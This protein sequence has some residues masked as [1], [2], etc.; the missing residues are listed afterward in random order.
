MIGDGAVVAAGSVI[1]R[2]VAA[3]AIAVARG[4]QS[5]YAGAAAKRRDRKESGRKK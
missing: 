3:D 2:D 4:K 5:E 1:T